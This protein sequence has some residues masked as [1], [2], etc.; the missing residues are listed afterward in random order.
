MADKIW[1]RRA[2]KAAMT[3]AENLVLWVFIPS[4]LPG[5]L[6]GYVSSSSIALN[7]PLIYSF[8]AVITGLLVLGALFDG[9][10]VSVP[11][12]TGAYLAE[13][14]YIWTF[15]DAGVINIAFSGVTV[16]F[17]FQTMVFIMALPS[18][19]SAMRTPLQYVMEESEAVKPASDTV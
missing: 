15:L 11:F 4:L 16:T 6:G 18:L 19:F 7:L 1:L 12:R 14:F 10:G 2:V 9:S 17:A 5:L 8:G 3:A 13:A